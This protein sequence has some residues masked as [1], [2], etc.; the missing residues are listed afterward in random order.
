[1]CGSASERIWAASCG[2]IFGALAIVETGVRCAA[3]LAEQGPD[4]YPG[5]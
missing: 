3:V 2:V 1:M 5:L 4:G